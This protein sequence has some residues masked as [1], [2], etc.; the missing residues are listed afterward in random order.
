MLP[1]FPL[2]KIGPES[3]TWLGRKT[4]L[5]QSTGKK[6]FP[7]SRARTGSLYWLVLPVVFSVFHPRYFPVSSFIYYVSVHRIPCS[8]FYCILPVIILTESRITSTTSPGGTVT[9]SVA[10]VVAHSE[11]GQ[12]LGLPQNSMYTLLRSQRLRK[13]EER[14][15]WRSREESLIL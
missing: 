14:T 2:P 1:Q 9:D 10:V 4:E 15:R 5:V 7:I 3:A 11:G 8:I 6:T 12:S 13:I